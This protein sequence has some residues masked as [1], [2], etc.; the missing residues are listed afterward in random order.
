[1]NEFDNRINKYFNEKVNV[2]V[3]VNECWLYIGSVIKC[4]FVRSSQ[5]ILKATLEMLGHQIDRLVGD[6][7]DL[8]DLA[9]W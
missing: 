8:D 1:M 3:S 6:S 7:G 9:W 5:V 2:Y 4:D